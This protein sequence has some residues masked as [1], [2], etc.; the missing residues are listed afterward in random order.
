VVHL[1]VYNVGMAMAMP[2]LTLMALD[3]FPRQRGL[4]ASCQTFLQA[5]MN[6]LAAALLAPLLWDTTPH[7][8]LG[9][10]VLL[11]LGLA[12]TLLHLGLARRIA[13]A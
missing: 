11:A 1:L 3:L 12:C 7:L 8:A 9:S 6:T 13:T 5:G 2:C 10:T 4:A